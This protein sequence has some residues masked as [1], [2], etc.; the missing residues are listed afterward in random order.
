MLQSLA[1]QMRG[2]REEQRQIWEH[3]DQR[4]TTAEAT[5]ATIVDRLGTIETKTLTRLEQQMKSLEVA[6]HSRDKKISELSD[7]MKNQVIDRR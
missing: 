5:T 6:T 4:M 2:D 1:A 3:I 7:K